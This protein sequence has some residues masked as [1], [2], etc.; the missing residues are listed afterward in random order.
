MM[1]KQVAPDPLMCQWNPWGMAEAEDD[2]K[3]HEIFEARRRGSHFGCLLHAAL[4]S[5]T[6]LHAA[7]PCHVA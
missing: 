1:M 3:R 6:E 4:R 5:E 2:Y 7:S